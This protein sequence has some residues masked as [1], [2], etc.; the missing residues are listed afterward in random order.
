MTALITGAAGGLGRAM[1]WECARRGY[2]LFLTDIC[3]KKLEQLKSGLSRQF[4]I[5]VDSFRADLTD[6]REFEE[7]MNYIDGRGYRFN[8]LLN[9]AGIDRE[10]GF[11][12]RQESEIIDIVRINVEA[13]TKM[14]YEIIKRRA[15]DLAIL[16]AS[17]LASQ[18][19]IPLKATYSASKRYLYDLSLSL[20][21]ELKSEGIKVMALCPGGLATTD[22]IVKAIKAQGLFGR[23][24]TNKMDKICRK[25]LDRML[26]GKAEYFP[27]FFNNCLRILARLFSRQTV[28][29]ILYKR[30]SHSQKKWLEIKEKALEEV[31]L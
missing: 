25:S 17:S 31:K 3:E 10:G 9:I 11:T 4:N 23:L 26:K 29:R 14:T 7:L 28:A 16:F 12:L 20:R 30:F 15:N 6:S 21:E 18:F 5:N 27:G 24:T 13:T 8:M 22:E 2:D 1:A 19:S